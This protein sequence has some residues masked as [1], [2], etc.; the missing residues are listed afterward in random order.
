MSEPRANIF[1]DGRLHLQHGPIDLIIS[2]SGTEDDVR[3]ARRAAAARFRSIL[4]ELVEEIDILKTPIQRHPAADGLVANRMIEAVSWCHASITPMAAVAGA[5]ADEVLDTVTAAAPLARAIVNNGG[6]IALHLSPGTSAKVALCDLSGARLGTVRINAED[7]VGGI[8]TSGRG[9]RSLTT[10]IADSVTV[11]AASGA[12]ADAAATALSGY[13]SLG[14]HPQV[15][16]MP[17]YTVDPDTDLGDRLV[18]TAV[19]ELSTAEKRQALRL[20]VEAA[21]VLVEIDVIREAAFV[22]KGEIAHSGKGRR[23]AGSLSP[24]DAD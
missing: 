9:G 3:V 18:V 8:A 16:R 6:D 23:L 5:V 2:L 1:P 7:G 22:L 15:R 19:G 24:P 17:A 12:E 11:L 21:D 10:G 13:V 20:G 14:D 4:D